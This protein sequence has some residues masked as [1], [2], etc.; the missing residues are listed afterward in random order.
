MTYKDYKTLYRERIER[1]LELNKQHLESLD[2]E[3][4]RLSP[5]FQIDS[6][7]PSLLRTESTNV[8][9]TNDLLGSSTSL[10]AMTNN[11][12]NNNMQ[13]NIGE[14]DDGITVLFDIDNTLYSKY[15]GIQ[16]M[17]QESI[18]HYCVNEMDLDPEYAHELME[19]YYQK[20]GL[21]I[22]GIMQDFP[23]TDP[24][25][26][27]AM[28]DDSL[29]LQD[30]IKGP[31]HKLR[32]MLLQLKQSKNIKKLWLF[33]NAYK[34]H[35]IRCIRI[36][37]I[38]DLFDGITY[39][40]YAAPP[41]NIICKPDPR[42]FEM[43]KLQSGLQSFDN[44]WFIDDSFANIQTAL[45]VGLNHCIFIDYDTKAVNKYEDKSENLNSKS[46]IM[47]TYTIPNIHE[48][49]AIELTSL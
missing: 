26:F 22:K 47:A 11:N 48:L 15:T 35:A 12:N 24:L 42:A 39:C 4:S 29:P 36:L 46:T 44:A 49:H 7:Q 30:A 19:E 17:M 31:D 8:I 3:G 2:Y 45:E 1:Q 40:D 6:V 23:D 43:V 18:M 9:T 13:S 14:Q 34:N 37:G 25:R 28:V 21:S 27:N 20:Y 10:S 41:D 5:T 32:M 38:A 16:K 33:T